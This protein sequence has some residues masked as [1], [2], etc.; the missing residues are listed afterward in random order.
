MASKLNTPKAVIDALE[1]FIADN[2][3]GF[4]E[5]ADIRLIR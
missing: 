4:R 1:R 3:V 2:S 5:M